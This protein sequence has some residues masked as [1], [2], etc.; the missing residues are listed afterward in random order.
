MEWNGDPRGVRG[1]LESIWDG[2]G[3]FLTRFSKKLSHKLPSKAVDSVRDR[4]HVSNVGLV[5]RVIIFM[6]VYVVITS[7][8]V[9]QA[10]SC[11]LRPTFIDSD[12][13]KDVGSNKMI[14]PCKDDFL[15]NYR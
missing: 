13:A 5:Q 6:T 11:T 1:K 8:Q 10:R 4:K 3:G 2:G 12:I 7:P 9:H 14:N 15:K